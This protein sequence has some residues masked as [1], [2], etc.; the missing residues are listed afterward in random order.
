MSVEAMVVRKSATGV[1]RVLF[2]A[3]HAAVACVLDMWHRTAAAAQAACKTIKTA[4]RLSFHNA[5]SLRHVLH[6]MRP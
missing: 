5:Y 2:L 1:E 6:S 4:G 3:F